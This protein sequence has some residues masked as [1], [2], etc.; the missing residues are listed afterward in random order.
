VV[1]VS[2]AGTAAARGLNRPLAI[3]VAGA[4]F[5]ENL[6]GTIIQTALP[7]IGRDFGV[8][9]VDVNVAITVYLIAVAVSVPLGGW[10][11]DRFGVRVVFQGAIALFTVASLACGLSDDLVVLCVLRALQ[12]LGGA[13][14]V[15]VGRLAVLR[16][17]HTRDLLAAVAYLTWPGLL[18]P[19]IA[20]ALGGLLTDTV[21]WRWIFLVNVPVGLVLL[22]AGLR[23][24]PRSAERDRRSFDVVGFALLGVGLVTLLLGLEAVG[25]TAP[26]WTS[27]AVLL[28]VAVV[29]LVAAVAWMRRAVHPLLSFRALAI[30]TFRASN[31]GGGVYR[32]VVSALPFLY[33]LL[34][35]VGFGFSASL[36]GVLVVAVFVG[37]I[38]IKPF[39]SAASPAPCSRW[40]SCSRTPRRRSRCWWSRC[41]WPV[42]SARSASRR[43]TRSSSPTCRRSSPPARTPSPRPRSR[44]R[45]GS[46]SRSPPSPCGRWS[47][48]RASWSP[49]PP[50]SGTAGRSASSPCC[51]S[52][53]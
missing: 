4:F 6:D 10:L 24:L 35:Q 41:W 28:G 25:G 51:S 21:G 1:A 29:T 50:G 49:G 7:A 47:R 43:T 16:V 27:I 14:M 8:R 45:S 17:T 40:R 13:L 42:R 12:G 20:P 9:A 52:S 23:L 44:S 36:A 32:L 37:N 19:V 39:T 3:L 31:L 22:L 46:A 11:A 38:G 53:R 30:P 18:A 2:G 5:M 26:D 33:T 15:P 48:S 34:F